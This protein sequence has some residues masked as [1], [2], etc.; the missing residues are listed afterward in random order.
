MTKA[1]FTTFLALAACAPNAVVYAEEFDSEKYFTIGSVRV[2]EM[3]EKDLKDL[4]NL[5]GDNY[6]VMDEES[7]GGLREELEE[8]DAIL[9]QIINIGR[10][11][12]KIAEDNRPVVQVSSNVANA[13][14]QGLT[15]W[16]SLEGWQTPTTRVY[17][18]V[19]EN[20][21]GMDVVDFSYR[22]TFTH[23]GNLRGKGRYLTQVTVVPAQ[24]DVAWGYEF[25]A[26]ATIPSVVNAGTT[27]D[28]VAGMEIQLH[29]SVD[30]ILKHSES[31]TSFFVRGDGAF[32]NL[33]NGT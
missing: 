12:W 26:E 19:Y 25:N 29:W 27:A 16:Q 3:D 32:T 10:K 5:G 1:V 9:D 17:R 30:T 18:V 15:A 2:Q 22:V 23:G 11:V 13:L 8:V 7:G 6:T 24:L 4:P 20:L 31:T 21:Y 28:P 14:P 33:S